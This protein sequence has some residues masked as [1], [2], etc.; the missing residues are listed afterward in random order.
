MANNEAPKLRLYAR[1]L[2]LGLGNLTGGALCFS[3]P[4]SEASKVDAQTPK[5]CARSV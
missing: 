3:V 5:T 1:A 2:A 4:Q